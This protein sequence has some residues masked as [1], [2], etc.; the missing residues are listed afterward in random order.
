[1]RRRLGKRT[2]LDALDLIVRMLLEHEKT[3]NNLLERMDGRTDRLEE[4]IDHLEA[5]YAP[6]ND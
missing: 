4:M 3:L 6:Q 1:M 2:K 5:L